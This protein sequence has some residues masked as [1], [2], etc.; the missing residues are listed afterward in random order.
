MKEDTKT[1]PPNCK[2]TLSERDGFTGPDRRAF[3]ASLALGSAG[4][5]AAGTSSAKAQTG[6]VPS[7]NAAEA[8]R[9]ANLETAQAEAAESEPVSSLVIS[10]PGSDYMVD[11]LKALPIDYVAINPGGNIRGF[12]ESILNYGSNTKPEIITVTHEEAGVAMAHGY[13]KAAGKPMAALM[14]GTIGLQHASMAVYNAYVDR[15]PVIMIAGNRVNAEERGASPDWNHSSNNLA[16][17]VQGSIK[18]GDEPA[19]ARHFGESLHRGY[20]IA[21]TQPMGPVLITANADIGENP[22]PDRASLTV[23]TYHPV[24]QSVADPAALADAARMLVEAEYPVIVTCRCVDSDEGLNNIV[25]LAETL[26]AA[27]VQQRDRLCMPYTHPL[28]M[29]EAYAQTVAKA[30]VVIFLGADEI[31]TTLF[32]LPALERSAPQRRSKPDVKVITIGVS[33]YSARETNTDYQRYYPAD[34][35]IVGAPEPSVPYLT[36]AIRAA[37]TPSAQSRSEARVAQIHRDF[38]AMKTRVLHAAANG[39]DASPISTARLSAELYDLIKNDD[40]AIVT[41]TNFLN[42][43][44]LKIMQPTHYYQFRGTSGAGGEGY[45]LPAAIG[46]GLAYKGSGRICVGFQTDGDFMYLPGSMWTAAHHQI[47]FLAIM[48]NNKGYHAEFMNIQ[49]MAALRARNIRNAHIGTRLLDPE[50]DYSSL[51][52]GLGVWATGPISQPG[53]LRAALQQAL[54][55]VRRGEPALVDVWTQPR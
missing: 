19:S 3:I 18:W 35:Q 10:D 38:D 42:D 50:I 1:P 36:Q 47:P 53:D 8:A 24:E 45:K 40:W 51:M 29:T 43:W 30:D 28:N 23:P 14:Y 41:P 16:A 17:I 21:M 25:E 12:H 2:N 54:E 34:L 6:N 46:A 44:P 4:A 5:L 31:W 15:V 27:V 20:R 39:W 26:G 48:H 22:L 33:D 7:V 13:F 37:M 32:R 9:E 11:C 55:V 52:R 49:R